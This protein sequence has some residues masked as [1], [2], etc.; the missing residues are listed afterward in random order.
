M[1]TQ[2]PFVNQP[3]TRQLSKYLSLVLRH[4]PG[5]VSA[6]PDSM[7]WVKVS[8]IIA[9]TPNMALNI[10]LIEQVA[11]ENDKQRFQLNSDNTKIRAVQGH[12][13]P[14]DYGDIIQAPSLRLYHGTTQAK[15]QEIKHAG[16]LSM[17]RTHVHLSNDV[18]TADIVSKR[19][20]T[21]SAPVI[22]VV[23]AKQAWDDGIKFY[24]AENGV[25]LADSIPPKYITM[26]E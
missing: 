4:N 12:S 3:S 14:V 9:N 21:G 23:E 6:T 26:L 11:N 15:W 13:F 10:E 7:G 17:G 25:W 19:W 2:S 20:K 24:L 22:L 18:E 5:L 8:D 16:L 1:A